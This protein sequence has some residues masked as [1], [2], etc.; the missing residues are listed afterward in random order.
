MLRAIEYCHER[1]V[2][3]RDLKVLWILIV[4]INNQIFIEKP[5]NLL[6]TSKNDDTTIK[7]VDFG[8]AKTVDG[9]GLGTACG[10][11]GYV[12]PEILEK[13]KYGCQVDVWSIGK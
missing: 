4:S 13:K 10:T 3:H 7:V 11:P 8:F 1:N 5:E 9:V 12:A 6:L 2:A